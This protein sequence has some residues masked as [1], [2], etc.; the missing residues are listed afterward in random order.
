M[1]TIEEFVDGLDTIRAAEDVE[2]CVL[3]GQSYGGFLAQAYVAARPEVVEQLVLSSSGPA[4]YA[5]G[6]LPLQYLFI[7][8]SRVLPVRWV[9]TLL[10]RAVLR[11]VSA[12]EAD[13][14]SWQDAIRRTLDDLGRDDLVSHFAVPADVIRRRL[15]TPAAFRTWNGRAAMLVARNDPTQSPKDQRRL[16]ELL[17]RPVRLVDLGDRGHTAVLADLRGYGALLRQVL[18]LA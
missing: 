2:R 8:L 9:R 12:P 18:A 17:G 3:V 16:E 15:V 4:D 14:A 10:L 1:R 6:W 11:V 5:R 7:G 13:L